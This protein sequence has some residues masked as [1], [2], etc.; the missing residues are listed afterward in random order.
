MTAT[1]AVVRRA[2]RLRPHLDPTSPED[3]PLFESFVRA[4]HAGSPGGRLRALVQM[5]REACARSQKR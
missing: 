5:L 2:G 3:L 1:R 4:T